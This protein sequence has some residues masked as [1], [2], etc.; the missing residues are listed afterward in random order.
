M[1]RLGILAFV[2]FLLMPGA[3]FATEPRLS[4]TGGG[5]VMLNLNG[6]MADGVSATA[7]ALGAGGEMSM[8]RLLGEWDL[9]GVFGLDMAVFPGTAFV[10]DALLM[11]GAARQF[12]FLSQ[13][14]D[15]AFS[16]GPALTLAPTRD[17]GARW[18]STRL[19][20]D[21]RCETCPFGAGISL[22]LQQIWMSNAADPWMLGISLTVRFDFW[23]KPARRMPVRTA[24]A[25][26]VPVNA[27]DED[28]DGVLLEADRCPHSSPGAK[29]QANGCEAVADGMKLAAGI[30]AAGSADLTAV[31]E[32]E[33][34]RVAEL[35]AANPQ[36]ALVL[37]VGAATDALAQARFLALFRKLEA[38]GVAPARILSEVR[39]QP[40]EDVTLSFRLVL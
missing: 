10:G 18:V 33:C 15:M 14:W 27:Q 4:A 12:H 17:A 34:A 28:G 35:M 31:G 24:S 29:V 20:A 25:P 6:R 3:V 40:S 13:I 21:L 16:A 8:P 9:R 26:A 30:F 11:A 19:Q 32:R 2:S 22:F 5:G 36:L 1:Q 23:G 37:Q 7:I 39:A 38:L